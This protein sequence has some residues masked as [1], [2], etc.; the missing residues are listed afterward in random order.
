MQKTTWLLAGSHLHFGQVT[1]V[2]TDALVWDGRGQKLKYG[3]NQLLQYLR[4]C[5][6]KM[7]DTW[8]KTSSLLRRK[9]SYLLLLNVWRKKAV[10]IYYRY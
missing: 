3:I 5:M 4:Q 1:L 7:K 8:A 10:K 6:E 2:T 9:G